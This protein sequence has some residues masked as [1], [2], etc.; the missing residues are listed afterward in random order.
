MFKSLI[1]LIMTLSVC[2]NDDLSLDLREVIK[3][4][5]DVTT[6]THF[7]AGSEET[8]LSDF[9]GFTLYTFSVDQDGQ[10]NC[11]GDCLITWP[12]FLTEKLSLPS[13]FGIHI[14]E[15]GSRQ[16]TLNDMPLYYFKFDSNPQ[17]VNGHLLGGV[18]FK[19]VIP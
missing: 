3:Q 2:A 18:W 14:R 11:L 10:S 9:D 1:I 4:L 15:D 8:L 19:V 7:N 12:A 6:F 5:D 17:D 13:P 16:V